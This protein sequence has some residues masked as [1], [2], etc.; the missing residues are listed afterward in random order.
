VAT[1]TVRS[2]TRSV[3]EL[4]RAIFGEALSIDQVLERLE[5]V[6]LP[7]C[8]SPTATTEL[9]VGSIG[10]ELHKDHLAFARHV[11]AAGVERLIDVRELPISRRRGYAKSALAQAMADVGVEYVHIRALGNPKAYRDLYKSGRVDEG[12]R[13]Y[14]EHLLG[15]QRGALEELV[16]LL[17]EK[18]SALILPASALAPARM[19]SSASLRSSCETVPPVRSQLPRRVFQPCYGRLRCTSTRSSPMSRMCPS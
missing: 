18:R 7:T 10:Y 8:A 16:P 15:E 1:A 17:R 5:L 4:T 9:W 2:D 3:V 6:D 13:R 19:P 11:Q 14:E 12:R